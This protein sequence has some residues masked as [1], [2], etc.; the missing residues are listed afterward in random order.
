MNPPLTLPSLHPKITS[1]HLQRLACIYVRQ[2]SAKQVAQ[3]KESQQYQYR[4]QQRAVE[5]GWPAERV[6]VIDSDLGRSGS[7]AAGRT[8]FQELVTEM[9]LGQVGIVFG[10]EVSRLA[11]NNQDWY[12]LL[13]LAA[14]FGTL[15]ADSDGVYDPRQY[16]DRLLLGL[17]GTMSEAELHLLRQR[18]E[19]GRLNQVKRGAYRQT[20]PTGYVRLPDGTVVKD[21]DD[22]VRHVLELMF[23]KFEELGSAGKVIRYLR[24][25][26]ILLPRRQ[27]AGP[28]AHELLW[29]VASESAVTEMLGNPAYAGAFAYGRR[30]GDATLRHPGRPATGNRR[31]A[32][33]D[34]VHLQLDAY[35][36]YITW[37]QFLANQER[38]RQNGL[39]FTEQR[40]RAQ[41]IVRDGPGLLQGLVVCGQC[42]HHMQTVYK[43]TPRYMCRGLVRTAEVKCE[44]T[45]VRAPVADDVVV[46]AFFEAIQPSQLDAL[47]AFLA[48][49]KADRGQLERHWQEQLRRAQYEAQLAQRQYD[50]VDPANRLVAAELERRWEAKLDQ[51]RQTEEDQRHF[52]QTPAPD[53]LPPALREIFREL[54][55]RLPDL[56]PQLSPAQKKEL[57]RSLIQHVIIRRPVPDQVEV[58]IV[59]ISGCYTDQKRITPIHREQDVTDYASLVQRVEALWQ[60]GQTDEQ[61]AAQLSREGFHSARSL[62]VTTKSVMKIRLAHQWYLPFERLRGATQVDG[63]WTIPGLAKR[64]GVTDG[65][66]HRFITTKGVI[67]PEYVEREPQTGRYLI[68]HDDELID[69][70]QQRVLQQ[71]RRNGM[72]KPSPAS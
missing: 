69:Q 41:G 55:R 32:L 38:I 43:H 68:R 34:W 63:C 23:S 18:L 48:Q 22:Q 9:S 10:Y 54:H 13:D 31:K 60:L 53:P 49:Q 70:L 12:R 37:D 35:P 66:I 3:N 52:L 45:S 20:L 59:W 72:L 36:A 27:S 46:Q 2:S 42:G 47:E 8:G 19:A 65:T 58:R 16:N 15:I 33:A 14:V 39:R 26:K 11:R 25:N 40:Q 61:I 28:H 44:C 50:T 17:K 51:L 57:L 5:L 56:W 64:L 71:K 21:P 6:R 29:K 62:Q 1:A 24:Q 67:P 4:L 7:E 30:Q